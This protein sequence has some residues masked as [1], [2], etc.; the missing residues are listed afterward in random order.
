M[1]GSIFTKHL[2]DAHETYFHHFKNAMY[3]SF[4]A[5]A[6]FIATFIHACLPFLFITTGSRIITKL[7]NIMNIRA[8]LAKATNCSKK[9]VAIIGGGAAGIITFYNLVTKAAKSEGEMCIHLFE[10]SGMLAKGIAYSTSSTNHFLNIPSSDMTAVY[11]DRDHFYNWLQSNGYSYK[12]TDFVPRQIFGLYLENLFKKACKLADEKGIQYSINNSEVTKIKQHEGLFVVNNCICN[13][14]ILATGTPLSSQG[15][16]S[17][18]W[19]TDL[20]K[21]LNYEE[22]VVIG[23][24]LTGMDAITSINKIGFKGKITLCSKDKLIPFPYDT[25]DPDIASPI[26]IKDA[27]LPLSQIVRKFTKSCRETKNWQNI[28]TSIRP[29]TQEFWQ[30]LSVEKKKRFMRHCFRMWNV[31]RHRMPPEQWK[32]ITNLIETGKVEFVKRRIDQNSPE[33]PK[34]YFVNCTGFG[35]GSL[36]PLFEDMKQNNLIKSDDINAGFVS[37]NK[38]IHLIGSLNFGTLFETTAMP[39]ISKQGHEIAEKI[40]LN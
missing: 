10:K 8:R 4:N 6:V 40:I 31:H 9:K 32:L 25:T 12:K 36:A 20:T 1:K 33:A 15:T 13:D 29:I 27:K 22:V 7:Y 38:N 26:S 39:E 28:F 14:I 30:A 35:F 23:S 17:S 2:R 16:R 5:L 3:F 19:S 37:L 34:Q 21:C 18:I 24:G 11:T